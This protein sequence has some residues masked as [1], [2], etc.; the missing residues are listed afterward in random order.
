MTAT[1]NRR[2]KHRKRR[3]TN[4][5]DCREIGGEEK[6]SCT[7]RNVPGTSWRRGQ[8]GSCF[9]V[10]GEGVIQLRLDSMGRK[11]GARTLEI[12]KRNESSPAIRNEG[13]A[14][15]TVQLPVGQGVGQKLLP[16]RSSRG[17]S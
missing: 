12:N 6:H 5:K 11:R 16:N 8:G 7:N 1:D 13:G 10:M 2:G 4:L 3:G 14:T 17:S 9:P 15:S